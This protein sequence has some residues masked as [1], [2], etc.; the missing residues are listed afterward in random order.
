M[1]Y[2]L[3]ILLIFSIS[4]SAKGVKAGTIIKNQA[5]M[6]F[7][8]HKKRHTVKS[9]I[10]KSIVDQVVDVELSWMDG[11]EV[12]ISEGERKKVLTFKILNSGN[13]KDRFNL[14][15]REILNRSGFRLQKSKIYIDRNHNLRFDSYDRVRKTISLN[16]DESGVVFVVSSLGKKV[17]AKNRDE[18]IVEL[19]AVSKKG[20]SGERGHI[21]PRKGV[22]RVDVIDGVSGGIAR[23]E[24]IYRF[25]KANVVLNKDVYQE[26][27]GDIVV[28][29]NVTVE[30]DGIAKKVKVI[31]EI[32]DETI[33]I[34][35][36]LKLDEKYI[37]DKKDSDEGRY[38]RRYKN[39]PAKIFFNLGD[40]SS[41]EHHIISYRLK[42]KEE[43]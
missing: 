20:G 37:S 6:S 10:S 39:H 1:Q 34:K 28:R 24:G 19:R 5:S 31:D 15:L 41:M 36:S 40:I 43:E 22:K 30:G 26:E 42:I 12:A 18:A 2:I 13:Y 38:K 8:L 7:T 4:L 29:I 16:E 21:Y 35:N 11:S 23:S 27:S 3:F 32:P 17:E 9:N 25:L 14:S 33:Y